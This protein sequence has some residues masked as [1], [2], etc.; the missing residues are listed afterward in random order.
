MTELA[1]LWGRAWD[2][3]EAGLSQRDAPARL[4]VLATAGLGGGAEARMVVLRGA[5][6]AAR[7]LEVH[8]DAASGKAAE[9]ARDPAATLLVWD[10]DA[11][12]QLRLR[13]Q[14]TLL[15]GDPRRWEAVPELSRAAYGGQPP[16]GVPLEH[17]GDW[18]AA[19]VISRHLALVCDLRVLEVLH[20]GRDLHRRARFS[21]GD[22]W[23]GGWVAP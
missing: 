16:P 7:R 14:V 11:M 17:P 21:A 3:L 20:L 22:S 8:T 6:R 15:P 5:D 18:T 23:L 13:V 19:P 1:E 4:P 2:M 9:L 10:P 12:L